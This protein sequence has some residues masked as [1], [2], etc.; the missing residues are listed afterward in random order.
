MNTPVSFIRTSQLEGWKRA[1]TYRFVPS[2]N[3]SRSTPKNETEYSRV[4]EDAVA[5]ADLDILKSQQAHRC[6][7]KRQQF[8]RLRLYRG[9][10]F[11]CMRGLLR[12]TTFT[13]KDTEVH[14]GQLQK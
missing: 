10:A 13:T 1:V 8:T 12:T 4:A 5:G 7:G 3:S 14:E 2:T 11:S 6:S 9:S